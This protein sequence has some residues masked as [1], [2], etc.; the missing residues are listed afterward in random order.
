MALSFPFFIPPTRTFTSI[1][2]RGEEAVW[3]SSRLKIS[4]Q[5]FFVFQVTKAG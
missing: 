2:W 1:S 4:M 5:G 3:D